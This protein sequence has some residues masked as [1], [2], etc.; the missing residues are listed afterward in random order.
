MMATLKPSHAPSSG[1]VA[2]PDSHRWTIAVRY[3]YTR[4]RTFF[5]AWSRNDG[6]GAKRI[7]TDR[8]TVER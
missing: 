3:E 5:F 7:G 4:I 8:A 6:S 2:M 1:A